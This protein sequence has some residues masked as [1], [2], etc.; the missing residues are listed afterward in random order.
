MV[1]SYPSSQDFM[2]KQKQ[3]AGQAVLPAMTQEAAVYLYGHAMHRFEIT[4]NIQST[5]KEV[6]Q[7]ENSSH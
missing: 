2:V 1:L 5:R 6:V 4:R 7:H 3:C